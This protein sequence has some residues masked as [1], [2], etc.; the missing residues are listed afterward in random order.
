LPIHDFLLP[1]RR[2]YEIKAIQIIYKFNKNNNLWQQK[3]DC[4]EEATKVTPSI[5]SLLQTPELHVMESLLRRLVPTIPTPI[6][7]Q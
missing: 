5:Q 3:S 1:L 7:L 2:L 6:P 4:R